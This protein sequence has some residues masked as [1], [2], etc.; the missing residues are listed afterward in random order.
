MVTRIFAEEPKLAHKVKSTLPFK[1]GHHE[2]KRQELEL[3]NSANGAFAIFF[4][5]SMICI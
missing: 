1:R 4:F 3:G 2:N 5:E